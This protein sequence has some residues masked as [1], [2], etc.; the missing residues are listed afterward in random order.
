MKTAAAISFFLCALSFGAGTA[1]AADC[2]A[3]AARVAS[4]MGAEVLS[5]SP[6]S[7]GGSQVCVI[8]VRIPGQ[9]GQPPRVETVTVSG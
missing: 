1:H 5:V 4:E 6:R 3:A 7:D 8:K 2:S 9:N